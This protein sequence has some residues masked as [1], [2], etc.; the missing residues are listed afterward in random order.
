MAD[1]PFQIIWFKRDKRFYIWGNLLSLVR[2]RESHIIIDLI[3]HDMRLPVDIT[4]Q[5]L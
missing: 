5:F 1:T 2:K 3:N 4:N